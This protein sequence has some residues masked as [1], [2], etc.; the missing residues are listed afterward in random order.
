VATS[1]G[2]IDEKSAGVTEI[3]FRVLRSDAVAPRSMTAGAAGAD[4][5]AAE[6]VTLEPGRAV[7]VPTGI[8]VAIPE[9]YEGQVRPRSGLALEHAIG[10]LNAPGTIDAD[11]RGEIRVILFNFGPE[12]YHIESGDR[13]A[14]L[15]IQRVVSV[16]FQE[17]PEL[18][19]TSR[20]AG[21]FG[22]TGR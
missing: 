14:Q 16:H 19:D 13:I 7:A 11:Y 17:H 10:V 1:R 12:P 2:S 18:P 4:L 21:G 3:A 9:G 5:S 20:G 8:A 22:H 6:T 15:V